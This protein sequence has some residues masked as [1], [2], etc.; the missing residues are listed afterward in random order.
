MAAPLVDGFMMWRCKCGKTS[1]RH[2]EHCDSC[3]EPQ[4]AP[5]PEAESRPDPSAPVTG[6]PDMLGLDLSI[7]PVDVPLRVGDIVTV[8]YQRWVIVSQTTGVWDEVWDEEAQM[9]RADEP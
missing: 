4:P 8:G 5:S 6:H 3:G 2:H 1:F 9:Q 7:R